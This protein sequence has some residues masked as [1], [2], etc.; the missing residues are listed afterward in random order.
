MSRRRR[1]DSIPPEP[2]NVAGRVP[3]HDLDAEAAVLSAAMLDAEARDRALEI[4][5]PEHF[6]SEA[7]RLI[8]DACLALSLAGQPVDVVTVGSW[9][10]SREQLPRIGGGAYLGQLVDA[11]PAVANVGAHAEVVREK[12]RIRRSIAVGQK[13]SAMGYGDCG[14]AQEHLDA[15]EQELHDIAQGAHRNALQP[16]KT[17][18]AA[19]FK[20][21]SDA[22]ARGHALTG[23]PTGYDDFDKRTGG[24]HP[25]DLVIVAAR[26]GMGKTAWCTNVAVNVSMPQEIDQPRDG[27]G[28]A[29]QEIPGWASAF[30]TCEMPAEQIGF[31][32]A[33]S[34]ARVDLGKFRQGYLSQ[35]DWARLTSAASV[36]SGLPIYV[37]DTAAIGLLELRAKVRRLQSEIARTNTCNGAPV[38]GL[39]L[40]VVDYLQLMTPPPGIDNREQQVSALSRGLKQLA[41][42]MHVPVV[43]L[44]QLNR[45]VETR[46][47]KDKRPVMADL[48]E[49]G[50]IEA[51]ADT[52]VFIYRDEYYNR[53]TTDAKGIAELIIAKQRNGPTGTV[54]VRFVD[55]ITRFEN[56]APHEYEGAYEEDAAQ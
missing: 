36:I 17:V 13:F 49:S 2:P 32:I 55:S 26:P 43:A 3:P 23:I 42:D 10:R 19:G 4:L 51:D 12:W 20:R 37:D 33:C 31:R 38:Q 9:L 6:F 28:L 15:F 29:R 48:R 24:L 22:A 39:G 41:K 54:R 40:V 44:S 7:N 11:T 34:E 46:S 21:V 18:L 56:L 30:F 45:G 47:A 52:I 53:D 8:F 25:G 14:P 1:R 16:I 27:G 5:K 35:D 50:A